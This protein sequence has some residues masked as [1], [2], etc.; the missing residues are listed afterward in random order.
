MQLGLK[1]IEYFRAVMETGSVSGAATL[2]CVS[3]PNVSRMLKYTETRL[4][5]TLF[6]RLKG[7][8]HPTP[9]AL[10]LFREIQ[11]LHAQLE[12]LQDSVRRIRNGESGRLMIGAS[13]SLGRFVVPDIIATLRQKFPTLAVKLDILSVSQ[14]IEYVAFGQ[15]ECA[16]TIFPIEHPQI[17]TD[18]FA[19][20]N[21]VCAVP[22]GHRFTH[23]Q[24][25][26]ADEIAKEPLIGFEPSTPHGKVVQAFFARA[27]VTPEFR[28][29]VRFAES[30]C[31]LAEHGSGL[32]LVDEFT[33]AGNAFPKLVAIRLKVRN[34]FRIYLHRPAQRSLSIA[35]H[36]FREI[37]RAWRLDAMEGSKL[38][39]DAAAREAGFGRHSGSATRL[40]N[41]FALPSAVIVNAFTVKK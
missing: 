16:C 41:P 31:A 27:G 21:L 40:S 33:M 20:G 4:G 35:G 29:I 13:P 7:R 26:T 25:L 19:T 36:H 24:H 37:L 5:M 18:T 10:A 3:Q 12:Q 22:V 8:L 34:P 15:G 11:P 28:S 32:A 1:Q 23:V 9:E 17:A 39:L 6:E 38:S 2:L 30:A 14:V